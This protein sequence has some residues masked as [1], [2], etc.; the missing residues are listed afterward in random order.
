MFR[1]QSQLRHEGGS[2][3]AD[4]IARSI[5]SSMEQN[6]AGRIFDITNLTD[7]M[8]LYSF[9]QIGRRRICAGRQVIL[10]LSAPTIQLFST[11]YD[12]ELQIRTSSLTK[13]F[14]IYDHESIYE[15][16]GHWLP[17]S[18]RAYCRSGPL[19]AKAVL[20]IL[21]R[22]FPVDEI[23][24]HQRL[25]QPHHHFDD[26]GKLPLKLRCSMHVITS[27]PGQLQLL[28]RKIPVEAPMYS[29]RALSMVLR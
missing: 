12:R 4:L 23:A 21:Q 15:K 17:R 10:S 18:K 27:L 16:C 19:D 26:L 5:L 3:P 8:S 24:R 28:F 7:L 20:M 22:R 25:Y 14:S 11:A 9:H 13:D 1:Y 29:L 2:Q 6:W